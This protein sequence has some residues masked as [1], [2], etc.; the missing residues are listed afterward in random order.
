[1]HTGKYVP[2]YRCCKAIPY[3]LYKVPGTRGTPNNYYVSDNPDTKSSLCIYQCRYTLGTGT[4]RLFTC[5]NV[6]VISVGH[7]K[8]PLR[9][10]L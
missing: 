2:V 7:F 1:M 6:F 9:Q 4:G 10:F 3:T 8:P 5:R